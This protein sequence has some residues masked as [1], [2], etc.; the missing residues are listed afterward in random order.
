MNDFMRYDGNGGWETAEYYPAGWVKDRETAHRY[1]LS[2]KDRYGTSTSILYP[3]T[4]AGLEKAVF[5][6]QLIQ[7]D[8]RGAR[9][10]EL[11]EEMTKKTVKRRVFAGDVT[12]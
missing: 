5:Q 1:V 2:F 10:F 4:A 7:H 3:P 11:A 9:D 12:N 8:D 6:M